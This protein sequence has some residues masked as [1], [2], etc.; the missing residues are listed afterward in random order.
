MSKGNNMAKARAIRAQMMKERM[1][2]LMAQVVSLVKEGMTA[3]DATKKV[4]I[5]TSSYNNWRR[6][7]ILPR[8]AKF[9][10]QRAAKKFLNVTPNVS[11][12]PIN[13][14]QQFTSS[15]V[16][17]IRHCIREELEVMFTNLKK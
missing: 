3:T 12:A 9:K 7:G 2:P 15:L 14:G 8:A 16:S 6:Q 4:G 1:T 10:K 5:S 11:E 13:E 17:L